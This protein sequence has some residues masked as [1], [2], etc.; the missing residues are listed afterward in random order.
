MSEP[1]AAILDDFLGRDASARRSMLRAA[2]V[3]IEI[4]ES[5]ERLIVRDAASAVTAGRAVVE[6]TDDGAAAARSLR[7]TATGLAYLGQFAEAIEC[8]LEA[9]RRA[10]AAGDRIEAARAL[11]AAMH[12]RCESGRLDDAIEGGETARRELLAAGA[13]EL[14]VRVDLNLGNIRK[15]QGKAAEA[16]VHLD[17]VLAELSSDDPIRAHALNA[18]GECRHVL[19]DLV[20]ADVAFADAARLLGEDG[21]LAA[22]IVR[23]NRG[24]VAAREGRLQDALDL[25][26]D[27][28]R[29]CAELGAAGHAARIA[30]E[31][32]ETLFH[33][34]L[35]DEARQELQSVSAELDGLSLGFEKAR[36]Q[37]ALARIELLAGRLDRAVDH[38]DEA[39]RGFRAIGNARLMLRTSLVAIEAVIALG[40]LEEAS[41]RMASL[42]PDPV[43]GDGAP[44]AEE[45]SRLAMRAELAAARG[46]GSIAIDTAIEAVRAARLLGVVPILI[47]R[48]ARLATLE[49]RAGRLEAALLNA[50][51]AVA[52]IERTRAGFA[53]NRLRTAFLN[54]RT[55]PY[56]TLV[57]ALVA[58]GDER[59]RREAF[60]VVEQA[61]SRGLLDRVVAELR[62]HDSDGALASEIADLRRRLHG[63]YAALDDD[64]PEEQ[65]RLRTNARQA[66]IDTLEIRLDRILVEVERSRTPVDAMVPLEEVGRR[67]GRGVA[68]IEYFVSGDR[69]LAFTLLD[70]VLDVTRLAVDVSELSRLTTELHFQCR[71]RLRGNPGEALAARMLASCEA[72]LRDLHRAVIEPLP[73]SVRDAA[74]WS[75]VP[76]GPL[77]AVPFQALLGAEGFVLD[78]TIVSMAPSA[79]MA[80]RDADGDATRE[81]VLVASVGD[82]RAPLIRDEGDAIAEIH[83]G[84]IRLD[85]GV[86][87]AG[88]VLHELAR[89]RVAHLAC[90]GRFLPGSP[91]SSG[92]RL[93]DRWVT[94]RDIDELERTPTVVILSGCETGLHPQSGANG[95]LGLARA[96]AAG[97]SRSIVSSLW[98]VHDEATRELMS[99]MH[100]VISAVTSPSLATALTQAQRTMRAGHR[101]P[102]F[103]APFFCTETSS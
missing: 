46:E 102:A 4:I 42:G 31:S 22:A 89:V 2:D 63:L 74:R 68:L 93:A 30:V 7:A 15:M 58:A 6:A 48:E 55:E 21:G 79:S 19:D 53:S 101:H 38:A 59:S 94:I 64:G 35:L 99:S 41:A 72:V 14:A 10:V 23:G 90:H 20:G 8:A 3:R 24:D 32:G 45:V 27:A 47:E 73:D 87:T 62:R 91:R 66:E 84:A 51:L 97:G 12:P 5:V 43:P 96:F 33:G 83:R 1:S 61:R 77:A 44:T 85:G 67:L 39:V 16:L 86:A 81:G 11:V 13:P 80:V 60:E 88:A 65:R 18:V 26:A 52:R 40:R 9:R 76:H 100:E 78:R 95:L 28:R 70:D 56:E 29:R 75:V 34:G 54:S 57:A 25:F 71:R 49:L 92:L 103:W 98:S 50:R 17:R 37:S 36:A 82:E 69:V